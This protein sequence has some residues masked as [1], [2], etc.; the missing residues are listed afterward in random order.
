M[1]YSEP[2]PQD[3]LDLVGVGFPAD[4]EAHVEMA[5][6]I[7]EEFVRLGFSE[8][9]LLDIFR[10]P[11]Y[12]SAY[13]ASQILGEERIETIVGEAVGVW[14]QVRFIDEE[15]DQSLVQLEVSSSMTGR[16]EP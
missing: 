1:P 10:N 5:Y 15:A 3:P 11:F 16:G 7:S 8:R 2:D 4:E 13:Q 14:G 9:R 12:R 6:V